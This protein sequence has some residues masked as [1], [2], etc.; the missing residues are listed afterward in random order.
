VSEVNPL[1][2]QTPEHRPVGGTSV[3][4]RLATRPAR[5]PSRVVLGGDTE[6]V[7]VHGTE[8]YLLRATRD[9]KLI[10]SR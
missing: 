6:V 3:A 2:K 9:G 7:I 5:I 8:E 10:L 1:N 4:N